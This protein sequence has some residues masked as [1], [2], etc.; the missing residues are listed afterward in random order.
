MFSGKI[1]QFGTDHEAFYGACWSN[2]TIYPGCSGGVPHPSNQH[3]GFDSVREGKATTSD[4]VCES[5]FLGY[6]A[7][8]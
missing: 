4:S 6:L 1:G 8:S 3:P 7:K 2:T 5:I